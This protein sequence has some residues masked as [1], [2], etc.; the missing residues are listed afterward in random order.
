MDEAVGQRSLEGPTRTR[1]YGFTRGGDESSPCTRGRPADSRHVSEF[2]HRSCLLNLK[3]LVPAAILWLGSVAA[4]SSFWVDAE[5]ATGSSPP[6]SAKFAV[7]EDIETFVDTHRTTP[8]WN[9]SPESPTR[10][11]VTTILYPAT[12]T[13]G[14]H[15]WR[16]HRGG[17]T[18]QGRGAL[19]AYR[20]RPRSW[21]Y[22]TGLHH[23][24]CRLGFRRIRRCST[25]LSAFQ[26]QRSWRS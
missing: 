14:G 7:G 20:L 1:R 15:R 10:T 2:R 3:W 8:A 25:A 6:V 24:A 19:P 17:G 11:L 23:L 5:A 26:R 9:Q 12:G 16:S 21:R 18:G 13:T 22:A 4:C